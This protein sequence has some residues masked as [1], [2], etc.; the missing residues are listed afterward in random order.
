M[1]IA[2]EFSK[3]TISASKIAIGVPPLAS[4][5]ARPKTA[6]IPPP[7]I[8]TVL[9]KKASFNTIFLDIF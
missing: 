4:K 3:A 2:H 8:P 1:Y 6:K 9:I 5:K 7:T